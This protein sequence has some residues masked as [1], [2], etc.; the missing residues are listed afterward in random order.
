MIKAKVIRTQVTV[1][2]ALRLTHTPFMWHRDPVVV[3][4]SCLVKA[5]FFLVMP[6]ALGAWR[7]Q[8]ARRERRTFC[9]ACAREVLQ[10]V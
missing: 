1:G 7:K 4:I 2:D 6:R 9:F 5:A 10:L 8:M 3:V